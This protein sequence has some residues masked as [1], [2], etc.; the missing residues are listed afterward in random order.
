MSGKQV[1]KVFDHK[2]DKRHL[3]IAIALAEKAEHDGTGIRPS[4]E[5][6]M[7]MTGASKRSVQRTLSDF[8]NMGFLVV[9]RQATHDKPTEYAFDWSVM[10]KKPPMQRDDKLYPAQRTKFLGDWMA[11]YGPTCAYCRGVGDEVFGPNGERWHVDRVVPGARGGAYTRD[12]MVLACGTCNRSKKDNIARGARL[13]PLSESDLGVP[14]CANPPIRGAKTDQLGVS[15]YWHPTRPLDSSVITEPIGSG[16]MGSMM[17]SKTVLE[18][19]M[20]RVRQTSFSGKVTNEQVATWKREIDSRIDGKRSQSPVY[21]TSLAEDVIKASEQGF[22]RSFKQ[23]E[24][25]SQSGGASGA[26]RGG[27]LP[28]GYGSW[29][30]FFGKA[31][32]GS[33]KG[34]DDDV[35]GEDW[36]GKEQDWDDIFGNE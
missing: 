14:N 16:H 8:R 29:D 23:A 25:R 27:K 17:T 19:L 12:N 10:E 5:R 9:T 15:Q 11:A 3:G 13:A 32:A 28:E 35:G 1:G 24:S 18:N 33:E 21:V 2:F 20:Q 36:T 34:G 26:G 4:V 7:W 30:E 22:F 31:S 6:L